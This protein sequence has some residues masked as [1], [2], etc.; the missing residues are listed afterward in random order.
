MSTVDDK[1]I[2]KIGDAPMTAIT[3]PAP[4][5]QRRSAATTRAAILEAAKARFVRESYDNV[6]IR[7]IAADVG[8]DPALVLRYAG[9]KEE[10]FAEVLS[11]SGDAREIW[12][13]DRSTFGA[14]AARALIDEPQNTGKLEAVLIMLRS[15][16]SPKAQDVI[17]ASMGERFHR[18][19]V[20]CLGGRPDAD[21][22]A[23]LIGSVMMGSAIHRSIKGTRWLADPA[24][25]DHYRQLLADVLQGLFDGAE[26][27]E[28]CAAI[29][30]AKAAE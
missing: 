13:G 4:H 10:L 25:K 6:G 19:A 29:G 16:S 1:K 23:A 20:E 26:C 7:D 27:A 17:R 14:R 11:C 22:R 5:G 8:V 3:G 2:Q 28:T 18:F 30:E 24:K 15:A 21:V 12:G 9:S